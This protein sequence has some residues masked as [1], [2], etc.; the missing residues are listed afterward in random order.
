MIWI[1]KKGG[2]IKNRVTSISGFRQGKGKKGGKGGRGR[3]GEEVSTMRKTS[4]QSFWNDM[5][6]L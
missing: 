2:T 6:V 5:L 1:S 3:L 4:T